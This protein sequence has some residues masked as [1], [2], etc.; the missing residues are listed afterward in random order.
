MSDQQSKPQR[1]SIFYDRGWMKQANINILEAETSDFW[2]FLLKWLTNYPKHLL[3]LYMYHWCQGK[4]GRYI[5]HVKVSFAFC[6]I[7][8][9]FQIIMHLYIEQLF[10]QFMNNAYISMFLVKIPIIFFILR[11]KE[12]TQHWIKFTNLTYHLFKAARKTF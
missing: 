12:K 5:H 11:D 6:H 7:R 4:V 3:Q 8:I 10:L 9:A 1:N 2:T